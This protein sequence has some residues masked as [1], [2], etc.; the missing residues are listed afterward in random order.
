MKKIYLARHGQTDA[1]NSLTFQGHIDNHLNSKGLLQA[2]KIVDYFTNH[3]LPKIYT[4]DLI[5]T[6][7]TARPTAEI[8]N[9]E[10]VKIPALKEISFGEWEGLSYD[11]IKEKWSDQLELFFKQPAQCRMPGGESFDDVALRVRSVCEDLFKNNSDK[12]IAIVS[13]GGVIRVQLCLLL[14]L[15]INKLWVFGVH[16]ASTTCIGKW[17]DRFTIEYVND[18]HYLND[19]V[20][21]DGIK[22]PK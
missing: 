17:Q 9:S 3:N 7:E 22:Y 2:K 19:N 1:N 11:E 6:V 4:S 15:D 20:N 8:H 12:N 18:T 21:S 5:R 10:I 14:G 16:N 13:H